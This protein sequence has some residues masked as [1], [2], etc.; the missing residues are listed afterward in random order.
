MTARVPF[1]AAPV[2]LLAVALA[3]IPAAAQDS[4]G[5]AEFAPEGR[6]S[7]RHFQQFDN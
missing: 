7:I 4:K 1:L 5:N 2:A 6:I 3:G